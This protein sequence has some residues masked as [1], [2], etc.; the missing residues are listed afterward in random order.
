MSSSLI[1][2]MVCG[3][4]AIAYGVI[5]IQ[6]I[7]AQPAGNARMQEIAAAIQQGA[8]AYL[9]RQYTTISIVGA[10][11]F[12]VLGFALDWLTA[13]GF[14]VGAILSGATGYIGMNVS[15]RANSRVAEAARGGVSP[16]LQVAFRGGAIT[17]LLVVGLALI[18]VAGYYGALTSLFNDSPKTAVDALIG[19]GFGGSLISVFARLGGGIFTKGAD[20]GA[21]LVG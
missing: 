9:N 16:A 11:L 19:L 14:L 3:A 10:I 6:W 1:F 7:L 15:V 12:V 8:K 17:G 4:I 18:G 13:I 21:D 5:S 20:V 2:A